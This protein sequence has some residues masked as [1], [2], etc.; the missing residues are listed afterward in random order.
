MMSYIF[1]HHNTKIWYF[2]TNYPY[3]NPYFTLYDYYHFRFVI[4]SYK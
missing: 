3:F 4:P 2:E 1:A